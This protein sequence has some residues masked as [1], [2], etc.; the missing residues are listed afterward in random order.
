MDVTNELPQGWFH[1]GDIKQYRSLVEQIPDK[2]TI[3]ELGVWKG[4]SVCSI[5][6]IIKRKNLRVYA[7][8]TFNGTRGD[9][10]LLDEAKEANIKEQFIENTKRFGI[11]TELL[12]MT[13]NEAANK[14]DIMFDLIFIDSDH[15]NGA[16]KQDLDNWLPKCKGIIVGHDY[17][18][19][20]IAQVVD[21]TFPNVDYIHC[22]TDSDRGT[23]WWRDL[24]KEPNHNK[25]LDVIIPAYKAQETIERTLCSIVMQSIVTKVSV[26]I[27]N[28]Y[29]GIGYDKFVK[30]FK[31]YVDIKEVVLDV[32]SGPGVARQVGIDSS[33]SPYFTCIDADDTFVGAFALERLLKAAQSQPEHHTIVGGFIEQQ[34]HLQ[35]VNHQQD[36]VWMFGKLYTR[37]FIDKYKIRFNE[38]RANEDNGFNTIIRLVSSETEKIMFIPDIVYCWHSKGDSITRVNYQQYSY[39]QSF[40]GFVD[41]MIYAIKQA[42]KVKPFNN[43]IDMWSIQTMAQLYNYYYQTVKRDPRFTKQNYIYC[44]KYYNEVFKDLYEKMD[45]QVFEPIFA[46][47][48]SQQA[49]NMKDNVPDKTI[50]QFINELKESGK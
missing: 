20:D 38:T 8:D 9:K 11:S 13:T 26:I 36:L 34:D 19:N 21:K 12:E 22:T 49:S 15:S 16:F 4:R 37:A 2:G 24:R 32:N 3:I 14:L 18:L 6:D 29:D 30:Q 10:L 1:K 50:Y 39:D 28:D 42:K 41:N 48:L 43:Y 27:V 23:M 47:T 33:T 25:M 44:V 5:A 40:V 17:E 31:D 35:F 46:E 45:K 7:V